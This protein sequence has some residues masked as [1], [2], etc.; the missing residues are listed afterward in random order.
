MKKSSFFKEQPCHYDAANSSGHVCILNQWGRP[1][2]FCNVRRS[3][4]QEGNIVIKLSRL[5]IVEKRRDLVDKL[6]VVPGDS[7]DRADVQ[8]LHD[9]F[10]RIQQS[11]MSP[12]FV[13]D[14]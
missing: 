9:E 14:S 11:L 7:G 10:G 2:I 6:D 13:A 12:G 5:R 3:R 8:A 4:V 1:D